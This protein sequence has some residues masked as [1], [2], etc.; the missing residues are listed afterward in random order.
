MSFAEN[1][2]KAKYKNDN[3]SAR[4]LTLN[5]AILATGI[6]TTVKKGENAGRVL[7][8]DFTVLN[9][10][11]KKSFSGYWVM[12]LPESSFPDNSRPALVAWVNKEG[13]QQPLQVTGGWLE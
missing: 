6:K 12:E 8:Q 11:S 10:Q 7:P 5:I 1:S 3:L 9:L 4:G 2:V 13:S